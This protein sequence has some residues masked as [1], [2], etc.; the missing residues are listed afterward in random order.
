MSKMR[1][2]CFGSS[3]PTGDFSEKEINHIYECQQVT[4]L[5][6]EQ[7]KMFFFFS[8]EYRSYTKQKVFDTVTVTLGGEIQQNYLI[9]CIK[10][11][12][13]ILVGNQIRL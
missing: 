9:I 5:I 6:S 11:I 3:I 13:S 2:V 10:S 4:R 12:S 8:S 7:Q 1:L